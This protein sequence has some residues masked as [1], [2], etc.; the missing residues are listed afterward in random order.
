MDY[1][2]KI[3]DINYILLLKARLI[4]YIVVVYIILFF[5][6]VFCLEKIL[7]VINTCLERI[8]IKLLFKNSVHSIFNMLNVVSDGITVYREYI[9]SFVVFFPF[10]IIIYQFLGYSFPYYYSWDSSKLFTNDI[11]LASSNI[12][13]ELFLNSNFVFFLL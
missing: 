8:G 10:I 4:I 11:L 2:E 1:A 13:P 6:M 12:M 3:D 9:I 5:L 7:A